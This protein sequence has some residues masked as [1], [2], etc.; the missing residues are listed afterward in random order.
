MIN[1]KTRYRLGLDLGTNS[2]GWAAVEIGV[3]GQPCG[4]LDMG[5]RIFPDG[6]DPTSEAS[7]AVERRV[8]RGQRRRRDRYLNRRERLMQALVK[9]GLMPEDVAARKD[10]EC[11]DPYELRARASKEQ[12]QPYEGNY[13][14]HLTNQPE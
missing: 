6:R 4:L 9:Y 10:L 1:S 3:G 5:V 8:A 2:I 11:L 7:N 12:L 14:L 13:I